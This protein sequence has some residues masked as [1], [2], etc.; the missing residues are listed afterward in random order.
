MGATTIKTSASVD[1]KLAAPVAQCKHL[2]QLPEYSFANSVGFCS[3]GITK[4]A[5]SHVQA[6]EI[7]SGRTNRLC[8]YTATHSAEYDPSIRLMVAHCIASRAFE[9]AFEPSTPV[10]AF[11][12]E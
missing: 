6:F 5:D 9:R 2:C 8:H 3:S 11:L 7:P 1:G 12:F 4:K 10:P